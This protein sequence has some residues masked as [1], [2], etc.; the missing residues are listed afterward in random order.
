MIQKHTRIK[1]YKMLTRSVLTYG[2][3]AWT[4]CKREE[5]RITAVER[6]FVRQQQD[7]LAWSTKEIQI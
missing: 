7:T 5:R 1:L 3:E 2:S 4:I 6:K